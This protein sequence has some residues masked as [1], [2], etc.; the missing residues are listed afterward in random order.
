MDDRIEPAEARTIAAEY[1]A[2][3]RSRLPKETQAGRLIGRLFAQCVARSEAVTVSK[4]YFE[5]MLCDALAIVWDSQRE[6][7]GI[8]P[9]DEARDRAESKGLIWYKRDFE[10]EVNLGQKSPQ[11][12]VANIDSIS[13][14][15]AS[16]LSRP[17]LRD[18]HLDWLLAD[19]LLTGEAFLFVSAV[20]EAI[21]GKPIRHS[22]AD[23]LK[24]QLRK[25]GEPERLARREDAQ[26]AAWYSLRGPVVSP[27]SVLRMLERAE[28]QGTNWPPALIAIVQRAKEIDPAVWLTHDK[29]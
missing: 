28:E 20:A 12:F 25:P 17:W 23:V 4:L 15:A 26:H 7:L 19:M 9:P 21:R 5:E 27:T 29:P 1:L 3:H 16:Y 11:H 18:A 8:D 6:A 13:E 14:V 24:S 10:L 22:F 2:H